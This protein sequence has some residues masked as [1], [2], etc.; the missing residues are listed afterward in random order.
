MFDNK[1]AV[2]I[3]Y[4]V[5]N[6]PLRI[7]AIGW[8][9]QPATDRD[10]ANMKSCAARGDGGGRLRHVDGLDYP[11]GSYASTE[12][13]IELSKEAAKLGGIYHTTATAG[14]ASLDLFKEAIEIGR[15]VRI[16]PHI[17]HFYQRVG[18]KHGASELLA[19]VEDAREKEDL[20]VTFDS[21][22]YVFS[23]T[24]LLILSPRSGSRRAAREDHRGLP[25]PGGARPLGRGGPAT[26]GR[27]QDMWITYFKS[28]TTTSTRASRSRAGD[29]DRQAR[30]RRDD[31]PAAGR[32]L[33]DL[34]HLARRQR[35]HP[36][37]VR[38]PSVLDGRIG[39]RAAR[40]LPEPT[41]LRL[42]PHPGALRPRGEL[43]L[44]AER[45]PQ[46]D[47]VPWP[48]A[49]GSRI[50][51]CSETASRPTSSSSTRRRSR[52]CRPAPSRSSSRSA[53]ST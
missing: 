37:E 42:L 41:H 27:W 28:R 23:G 22:P 25:G 31:G 33:A 53:S 16:A 1:V 20:D 29:H 14:D 45:D 44:A 4:I 18:S 52:R 51:G 36:A 40:R 9:N 32:G 26:C 34:V 7:N 30:R 24:R 49:W 13:L 11:P 47:L 3:C 6:S 12:E 2:N 10:L 17:T 21:Y 43:P 35:E 8:Q 48:S 46:D 50:V 15:T 19:L 5:G 38:Q 39:R